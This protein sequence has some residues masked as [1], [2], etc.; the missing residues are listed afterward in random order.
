LSSKRKQSSRK[1]SNDDEELRARVA[2]KVLGE[3]LNVKPGESITIE[4]WSTGLPLAKQIVKEARKLG[5]IPLLITED[6]DAYLYGIKNAPREMIGKMGKHEYAL[7]SG[8]D[9]YV[10]IPGPPVAMYNP[11]LTR[12]EASIA[13]AYN[14]S[15]YEAAEKARLRGVRIT[16]GYVGKEYAKALGRKREDIARSLLKSCLVDFEDLS[17]KGRAIAGK[18][19]DG[20]QASISS[21]G[22]S[23]LDFTLKGDLVVEDGIVDE[24]DLDERNNVSY[25]PAGMVQKDVDPAS[26]NGSVKIE[27]SMTRAGLVSEATLT[28]EAGKLA[29]WKAPPK[30]L[31]VLEPILESLPES[32]RTM[33][34]ITI[35]F[36]PEMKFGNSQD[37]F[38]TGAIGIG[39]FGF[40]GIVRKG[41]LTVEGASVVDRGRIA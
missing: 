19:R 27:Q 2:S 15:W 16:M 6:E 9:A 12:E 36:N 22:G 28:F 7:L 21:S 40:T 41:T 17:S 34:L 1:L 30:S 18:L 13:T 38:V 33:K 24:R 23:K 14:G 29:S 31:K 3:T 11:M 10:F 35:G 5:A 8:S 26:A 32:D 4:T 20:A 39:G 25:M 37:R